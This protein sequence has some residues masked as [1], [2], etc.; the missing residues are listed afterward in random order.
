MIPFA[1][2]GFPVPGKEDPTRDDVCMLL[3]F[4]GHRRYKTRATQTNLGRV[5]SLAVFRLTAGQCLLYPFPLSV[6]NPAKPVFEFKPLTSLARALYTRDG[7]EREPSKNEPNQNPGF[8][9]NRT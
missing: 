4:D 9:K 7:K 5:A 3:L 1:G 8:V 6:Q 2:P